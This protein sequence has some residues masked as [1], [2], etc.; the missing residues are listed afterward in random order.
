MLTKKSCSKFARSYV[1]K[2][3]NVKKFKKKSK[4]LI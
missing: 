3:K 1:L 2:N 4:T